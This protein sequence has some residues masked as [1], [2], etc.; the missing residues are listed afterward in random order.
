[1]SKILIFHVE[2]DTFLIKSH[3]YVNCNTGLHILVKFG[4]HILVIEW[5]LFMY[6]SPFYIVSKAIVV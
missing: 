5:H 1:M 2:G 6:N 4:T 3:F